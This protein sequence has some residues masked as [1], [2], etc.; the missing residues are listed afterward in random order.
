MLFKITKIK[1][2]VENISDKLERLIA[3]CINE[4]RYQNLL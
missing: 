2:V 4:Q 1:Q 3:K